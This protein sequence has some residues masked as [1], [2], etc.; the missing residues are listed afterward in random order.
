MVSSDAYASFSFPQFAVTVLHEHSGA[1]TEIEKFI[2]I[3]I[4]IPVAS[5]SMWTQHTKQ[6]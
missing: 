6:D 2:P 5:V 1:F 4:V 3:A